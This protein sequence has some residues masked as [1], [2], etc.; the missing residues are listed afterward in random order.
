M[1]AVT[2]RQK[3]YSNTTITPK[4]GPFVIRKGNRLVNEYDNALTI[5]YCYFP[6]CGPDLCPHYHKSF[7][8][9]IN[10]KSIRSKMAAKHCRSIFDAQKKN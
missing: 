5:N 4:V 2:Y 10:F 6:N 3:P 7:C 9:R 8:Y 1:P